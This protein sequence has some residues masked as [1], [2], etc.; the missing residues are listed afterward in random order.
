[1]QGHTSANNH[2][3]SSTFKHKIVEYLTSYKQKYRMFKSTILNMVKDGLVE[4]IRSG[5][6]ANKKSTKKLRKETKKAIIVISLQKSASIS[7][8]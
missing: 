2:Q 8:Y 5:L 3:K 1:M 6:R 4:I 7:H